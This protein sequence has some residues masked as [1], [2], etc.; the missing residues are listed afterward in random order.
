[1]I[2]AIAY[3]G[4]DLNRLRELLEWIG[5][6]GGCQDHACV[7]AADS[8]V[9]LETRQEMVNLAKKQF[10][11]VGAIRVEVPSTQYRG[12]SN[13]MFAETAKH[14]Q[15]N[16]KSHFIWLEPDCVP[17]KRNWLNDLD[18]AYARTTKQFMGAIIET[19]GQPNI[20]RLHLT[21]CSIYPN[22]AFDVL[23]PFLEGG[24]AWDIAS[25]ETVIP[26][27]VNTFLVHHFY[28]LIDLPPLFKEVK[29]A[30]DPKNVLTPEF[31]RPQAVLFHRCKAGDLIPILRKRLKNP[32]GRPRKI[33]PELEVLV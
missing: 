13:R 7:L 29:E 10:G 3:H 23:A 26:K 22:R 24:L 6:L 15:D 14:I 30:G 28:G 9:P 11:Y 8:G 2:A 5:E 25:A 17:L 12:A 20:P 32:V 4:G 18:T 1:V 16:Y 27:T 33:V 21:G 19:I 31:I